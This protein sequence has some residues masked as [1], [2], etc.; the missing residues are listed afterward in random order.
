MKKALLVG[1]ND[2]PGTYNDLMGCVN[3]VNNMRDLLVSLFGFTPADISVS[4]D[5]EATTANILNGLNA[6]VSGA[7]PGDLLVFHY[8]GHGSQVVDTNGDETDKLD[9]ILCPYDLD[10][11][12]KM[13]RDDDLMKIFE[14]VPPGVHIEV[15]L[16]SCHSGTGLKLMPGNN[17]S[18]RRPRFL[19]PPQDLMKLASAIPVRT[20][21]IKPAK[22]RVLWAGCRANQYAS[23]A[24]IDGQYGGA[25]TTF[26]CN[27]VR[28]AKGNIC[29]K[30]L[31]KALQTEMKRAGFKQTP[32]LEAAT[33][34]KNGLFLST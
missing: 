9:E 7:K 22:V 32:Q 28:Q 5:R 17:G 20:T 33:K 1:I 13:I 19:A 34:P 2:Y 24:L 31:I 15:F 16:D 14:P 12:T 11:K 6:L 18:Y 10:W 4:T 29:R 26:L 30:D 3:D 8:S 25:F 21:R 23:D 27:L